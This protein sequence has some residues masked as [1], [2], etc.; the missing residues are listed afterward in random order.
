[1]FHNLTGRL[2]FKNGIADLQ[3]CKLIAQGA[4]ATATGQI[5]LP[6]NNIDIT[7]KIDVSIQK[8]PAF[9]VITY[10]NLD[11]PSHKLDTK[12]LKKYLMQNL[13]VNIIG[14]FTNNKDKPE[15][16][17]KDIFNNFAN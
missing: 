11:N 14:N 12:S 3:D 7:T 13:A 16:F 10:G 6:N 2:L 9:K 1:M 17:I 4:N 15:N 8:I 5:N